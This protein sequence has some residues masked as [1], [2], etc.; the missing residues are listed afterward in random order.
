M[1]ASYP[2]ILLLIL[3]IVSSCQEPENPVEPTIAL[4]KFERFGDPHFNFRSSI[5]NNIKVIDNQLF[6]SHVSNPGFINPD[7]T[8]NQ[9]CC[10]RPNQ[11]E[12]RQSL[13]KQY[14]G[15]VDRNLFGFYIFRNQGNGGV[16]LLDF[17]RL[18]KVPGGRAKV[19]SIPNRLK[20]FDI[21]N[22]KLLAAVDLIGE[23]F[24]RAI[25]LFDIE[26][27]TNFVGVVPDTTVI[28]ITPPAIE[29]STIEG[30]NIIQQID[31]FQDG[32]LV[33]TINQNFFVAPDGSTTPF[34]LRDANG[35]FTPY[36]G[37][38]FTSDGR[39]LVKTFRNLF[40]SPSGSIDDLELRVTFNSLI[41]FFIHEDRLAI[42]LSGSSILSEVE[43][44][45]SLDPELFKIRLLN[46]EGINFSQLFA[47]QKFQ[48]KVFAATNQGL[49]TKSL[50]SFWDSAPENDPALSA[51]QLL[52]GIAFH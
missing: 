45:D 39:L 35:N 18:I 3:G 34:E 21:N 6:F 36:Y 38:V 52:N 37:H 20:N 16:G 42:W 41:E 33:S 9:L 2:I 40:I 31:A 1:K 13:T 14:I 49:F 25:Y 17:N 43:N 47:L 24:E 12:F 51:E 4:E 46:S 27:N 11:M 50:E 15:A 19:S 22:G 32:W 44:F 30:L 29:N 8:V 5:V 10:A 23:T 26:N 48:G 28:K 7:M